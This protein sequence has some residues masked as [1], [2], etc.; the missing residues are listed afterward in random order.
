LTINKFN[1]CEPGVASFYEDVMTT[2][3]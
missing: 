2:F 3:I 1:I